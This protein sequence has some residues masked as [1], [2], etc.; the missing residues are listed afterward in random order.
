MSPQNKAF[1]G[2]VRAWRHTILDMLRKAGVNDFVYVSK[3]LVER[4][5]ERNIEAVDVLRLAVPVIREFRTTT[6]NERTYLI[7]SG[8]LSLAAAIKL[9]DT[10]ETRRVVLKTIYDKICPGDF[11]VTINL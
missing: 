8:I 6:Y 7:S 5:V 4:A 10:T 1:G 3:H 2:A 9:G 11:D